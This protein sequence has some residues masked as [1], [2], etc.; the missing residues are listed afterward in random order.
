MIIEIISTTLEISI[1]GF[2]GILLLLI[3]HKKKKPVSKLG[4]FLI[5]FSITSIP[6]IFDILNFFDNCQTNID[7]YSWSYSLSYIVAY[8]YYDYV[9]SLLIIPYKNTKKTY[10]IIGITMVFVGQLFLFNP[11]N[12]I[13]SNLYELATMLYILSVFITIII[14]TRKHNRRIKEQYSNTHKRELKWVT[15]FTGF[16]FFGFFLVIIIITLAGGAP[17]YIQN[18]SFGLVSAVWVI[19]IVYNGL[20]FQI[21]EN[22]LL[23]SK[24]EKKSVSKPDSEKSENYN[25]PITPENEMLVLEIKQL[26]ENKQLFLNADLTISDIAQNLKQHPKTISKAINGIEGKNFNLFINEFRVIFAKKL[27]TNPENKHISIEGIGKLSGF[28]SNS[29]FYSAFKNLL[30]ITPLQYQKK[31]SKD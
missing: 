16:T 23:E 22:L 28:R 6:D 8:L 18:I 7:L 31:N 11:V 3:S 9:H 12:T 5:A 26:I 24:V 17:T 2:V 20:F 25:L 14:Q 1:S 30:N 21:S 27:L 10:I 19:G 29:A 4:L 13:S 15:F